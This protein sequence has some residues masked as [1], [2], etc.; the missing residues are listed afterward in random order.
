MTAV[1]CG[2]ERV[3]IGANDPNRPVSDRANV[4]RV[5]VGRVLLHTG[6]KAEDNLSEVPAKKN[7]L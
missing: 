2:V 1:S 6:V 5:W 7:G 3:A 4:Q